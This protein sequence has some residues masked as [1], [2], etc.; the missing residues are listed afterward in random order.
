MRFQSV[1]VKL[2][3]ALPPAIAVGSSGLIRAIART[4]RLRRQ[5]GAGKPEVRSGLSGG[6]PIPALA[7]RLVS[8]LMGKPKIRISSAES[9]Q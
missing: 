1:S 6:R 9:R 2:G 5:G 4:S 3:L 8:S 7:P